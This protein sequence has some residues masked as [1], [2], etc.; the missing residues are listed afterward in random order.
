MAIERQAEARA[1]A[2]AFYVA[3][4][5]TPLLT[6]GLLPFCSILQKQENEKDGN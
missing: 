6:R 3:P 4:E 5:E 2:T 1:E